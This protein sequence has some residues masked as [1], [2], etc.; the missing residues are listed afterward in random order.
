MSERE[1][2]EAWART[3]DGGKNL[4][5]PTGLPHG[6]TYEVLGTE[7]LWRTW[8]A[9]LSLPARAVSEV[10]LAEAIQDAFEDDNAF[11]DVAGLVEKAKAVLEGGSDYCYICGATDDD[12]H[13]AG[14]RL[15]ALAAALKEFE[16]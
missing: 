10:E 5:A 12:P 15:A 13:L 1:R 8:Q 2:F 11:D 16:Q 14:C 9:A 4:A 3:F 6:W 7:L